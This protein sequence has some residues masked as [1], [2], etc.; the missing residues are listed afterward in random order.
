M[1]RIG[2]ITSAMMLCIWLGP[3]IAAADP[4]VG[5]FRFE[6]GGQ[7]ET[8]KF[9]R[10]GESYFYAPCSAGQCGRPQPARLLGPNELAS[11]FQPGDRWRDVGAKAIT[12]DGTGGLALFHVDRPD[13]RILARTSTGYL[14]SFWI[15]TGSAERVAP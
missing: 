12:V 13:E 7:Q 5:E 4:L 11:W 10:E 8:H 9:W 15:M 14:F 1:R 6:V 3:R 2:L